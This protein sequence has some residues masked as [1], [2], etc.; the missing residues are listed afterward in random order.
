VTKHGVVALTENLNMDLQAKNAQISC[1][2]LCPGGVNTNIFDS[3]R[4]RPSEL[5]NEEA[6]AA[7][8][9]EEEKRMAKVREILRKSMP[10]V[11]IAEIV[12][13]AIRHNRLYILTQDRFDEMIRTRAENIITG[14]NPVR[15]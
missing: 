8:T 1:S 13:D 15:R 12:F 7:P 2:V 14:T 9:A 6:P 11:E 3:G 5:A 10:P 4:N